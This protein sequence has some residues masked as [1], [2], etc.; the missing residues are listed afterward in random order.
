M[1]E[2]SISEIRIKQLEARVNA[3]EATVIQY[4][5]KFDEY[6]IS[7]N[8][9]NVPSLK[10]AGDVEM[11]EVGDALFVT[12]SDT[13]KFKGILKDMGG[14]WERTSKSWVFSRNSKDTLIAAGIK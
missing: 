12:G 3:L 5:K 6:I 10:I 2:I 13:Y 7:R 11:T 14:K 8:S 1:S 9:V 4:Q